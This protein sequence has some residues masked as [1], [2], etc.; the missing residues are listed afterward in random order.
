MF[1]RAY[2][3]DTK[4]S[5]ACTTDALQCS[6]WT[7]A[8]CQALTITDRHTTMILVSSLT[9]LQLHADVERR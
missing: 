4:P 3:L 6:G 8:T 7:E 2:K 1:S 9:L 5:Q